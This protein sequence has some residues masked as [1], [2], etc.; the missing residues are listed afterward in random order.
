MITTQTSFWLVPFECH[1]SLCCHFHM[2]S[3]SETIQYT[4][5]VNKTIYKKSHENFKM[6]YTADDLG[7]ISRSCRLLHQISRKRC[8]TALYGKSYCRALIGNHT[9]AF[10][11]CHFWWPWRT[12]ELWRSRQSRLSFLRPVSQKLYKIRPQ[13]FSNLCGMLSRRAVSKQYLS[14]LFAQFANF[15]TFLSHVDGYRYSYQECCCR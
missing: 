14:F 12:F 6:I 8:V 9:L 3:I 5:T 15:A 1:F 2:S 7:Y 13:Y 11:W 10:D 4:S